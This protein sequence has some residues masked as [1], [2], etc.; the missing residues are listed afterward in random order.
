MNITNLRDK[1]ITLGTKADSTREIVS[2]ATTWLSD[3]ATIPIYEMVPD[4]TKHLV[5]AATEKQQLGI[6]HWFCGR[7]TSTW[8]DLYNFDI[9]RSSSTIKFP[10]ANRWGKEVIQLTWKFVLDCWYVRLYVTTPSTTAKI[11]PSTEQNKNGG[12][13]LATQKDFEG[14]PTQY[15]TMTNGDLILLPRENLGIMLEQLV[16]IQVKK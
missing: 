11:I 6:Q 14:I 4:A 12:K 7:L 1:L 13:Y 5:S 15:K 2:L 9:S 16:R 8:G 3:T 10:S